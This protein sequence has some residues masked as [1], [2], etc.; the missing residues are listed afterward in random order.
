MPLLL[1]NVLNKN[2]VRPLANMFIAIATINSSDFKSTTN[3]ANIKPISSPT[4]AAN[5]TPTKE[6]LKK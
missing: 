6:E 3:T 1:Q 2:T 5:I 4:N